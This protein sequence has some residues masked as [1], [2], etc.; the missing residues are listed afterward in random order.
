MDLIGLRRVHLP[1][2]GR[3]G[4]LDH[5]HRPRRPG[6]DRRRRHAGPR[7]AAAAG[8]A[9]PPAAARRPCRAG[10]SQART[11]TP[12]PRRRPRAPLV[13]EAPAAEVAEAPQPLA[14]RMTR[15]RGRLARS[16]SGFGAVLLGL[17][18]RDGLD[19]QGWEEIEDTLVG[20][21]SRGRPG[22]TDR[23]RAA[24]A[25]Q[26]GR[27]QGH[28]RGA[29]AAAEGPDRAG[30]RRHGPVAA[31]GQARRPA[32]RGAHG[33]GQRHRQDVHLRQAGPCAHRRRQ[34][35]P[36]RRR[37][38]VPRRR[39]R[40]AGDLGAAGRAPRWSARTGRAPTR[41]ASRSTP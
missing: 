32:R 23:Q 26:G 13:A 19:D 40:P 1:D 6:P 34:H 29:L 28:R 36:A 25:G 15:L 17:L 35:G 3:Y 41:R 21:R 31:G 38:H 9:A 5:C 24:H 18:S 30:R 12:R 4:V 11:R 22:G 8:T 7:P 39:R 37:R 20:R 16:Q 2:W 33:G 10:P 27:R 14:G